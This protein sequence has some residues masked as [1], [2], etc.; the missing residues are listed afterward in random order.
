MGKQSNNDNARDLQKIEAEEF[1]KKYVKFVPEP[2]GGVLRVDWLEGIKLPEQLLG[3]HPTGSLLN[4][5]SVIHLD[6]WLNEYGAKENRKN[7]FVKILPSGNRIILKYDIA[8]TANSI[9]CRLV[10][11]SANWTYSF[12]VIWAKGY[13]HF[14]YGIDSIEQL[15]KAMINHIY[16]LNV[17]EQEILAGLD[18]IYDTT[19]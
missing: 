15:K 7:R 16:I 5:R 17:I 4:L 11:E 2:I 13:Q 9:I 19:M 12:F 10:Y 18:R 8:P 6:K 3:G 14:Q 1:L